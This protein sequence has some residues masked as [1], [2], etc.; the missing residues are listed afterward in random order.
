MSKEDMSVEDL[1]EIYKLRWG[2]EVNFNT[3]KHRFNIENFT[4]TV[5]ITH[6]QDLYSQFIIYNLFC[7]INNLLNLKL[8]MRFV[9]KYGEEYL[10]YEYE[11]KINQANLIR[12]LLEDITTIILSPRRERV[13][14]LLSN[15]FTECVKDPIKKI[16]IRYEKHDGKKNS[17]KFR[18]NC[19]PMK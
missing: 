16:K 4:G 12:N 9:N 1:K 18:Q 14:F 19:K 3:L 6:Q 17:Q 7:Y 5:K 11:Y 10:D 2:I 13:I 15:L 8:E